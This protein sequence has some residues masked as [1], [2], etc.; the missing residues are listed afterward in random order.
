MNSAAVS[1]LE[2]EARL[3]RARRLGMRVIAKKQ[4]IRAGMPYGWELDEYGPRPVPEEQWVLTYIHKLRAFGY[5][6]REIA[7]QIA[8]DGLW[9]REG[10]RFRAGDIVH[11]LAQNDDLLWIRWKKRAER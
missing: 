10:E 9:N 11:L 7:N 5:S 3:E 4:G 8:R 1:T 6:L 2:R